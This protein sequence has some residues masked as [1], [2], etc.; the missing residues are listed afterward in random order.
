[1]QG[2]N[3]GLLHCQADSLPSGKVINCQVSFGEISD[4]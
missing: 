3:P 2:W 1:M 4:S